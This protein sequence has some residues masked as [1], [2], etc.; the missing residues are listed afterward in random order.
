ME[1]GN[2]REE[3]V[4]WDGREASILTSELLLDKPELRVLGAPGVFVP[5]LRSETLADALA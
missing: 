2:S 4:E 3:C 1:K 5:M